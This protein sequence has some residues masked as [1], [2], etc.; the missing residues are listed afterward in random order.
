MFIFLYGEDTY[1][2]SQKLQEIVNE[3]K[4]VHET[5]LNL[6][7]FDCQKSNFEEFKNSVQSI[8]M[9]REKKLI[10][11]KQG[12]FNTNFK[13]KFL[14]WA[15]PA[16]ESE[17]I[18]IV[19]ENQTVKKTDALF[20]FLKTKA[21]TQ[22]FN[23]LVGKKLED[24]VDKE[25]QKYGAKI[26]W[27]ARAK[28]INFVG[29]DLWQMSQEIRKLSAYKL[30]GIIQVKDVELLVVPKIET[31]IFKTIDAI[32]QKNKELALLLLHKHLAKGDA[33]LYL[34][35]M[36]NFQFRNLLVVKDFMENR[37]NTYNNLRIP[38]MHPYVARKSSAQAQ[39]FTFD[40][41][42]KIYYKLL[43]IDT[44]IKTGKVDARMALDMFVIGI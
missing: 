44:K 4:K 6:I 35:S 9:F 16:R 41:L 39:N 30:K 38:G 36:I 19:Y 2:S 17:N 14:Q 21:K 22:E 31:D 20:K 10:I 12:F 1:R 27:S 18:I 5:G 8:S 23:Y 32:A 15:K 43:A 11:L 29:K 40:K 3:Y 34:L 28:L 25:F 37:C 7:Y 24:W 33:P 42:K 13:E 26:E